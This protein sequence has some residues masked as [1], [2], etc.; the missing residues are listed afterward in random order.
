MEWN[1]NSI[2]EGNLGNLLICGNKHS[3][4]KQKGQGVNH[5]VN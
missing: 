1:E 4:K 2:T 3:P 5:K